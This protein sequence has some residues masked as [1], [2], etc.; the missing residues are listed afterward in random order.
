MLASHKQ[1]TEDNMKSHTIDGGHTEHFLIH[2]EFLQVTVD[3]SESEWTLAGDR[4]QY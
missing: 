4:A 1:V 3:I 2:S